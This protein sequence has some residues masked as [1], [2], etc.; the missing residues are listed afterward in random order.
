MKVTVVQMF[1]HCS[2]T[3][4]TQ[5][6]AW[7]KRGLCVCLHC[8]SCLCLKSLCWPQKT[9]DSQGCRYFWATVY[10]RY[11]NWFIVDPGGKRQLL[12]SGLCVHPWVLQADACCSSC[13]SNLATVRC[14]CSTQSAV[15]PLF[16]F[17]HFN[18]VQC[19]TFRCSN[20]DTCH[21]HFT[22][23]FKGSK[24]CWAMHF[25]AHLVSG[26]LNFSHKNPSCS[27]HHTW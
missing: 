5:D 24:H 6:S 23:Y 25:S 10:W 21:Q 2:V 27:P 15:V 12:K 26:H 9:G 1:E 13:C 16:L 3:N 22:S 17:K 11:F 18:N 20:N 14:C 19:L 4:A 8:R 7:Q